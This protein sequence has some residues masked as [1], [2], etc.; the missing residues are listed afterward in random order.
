MED[1]REKVY[2]CTLAVEA[3]MICDLLARAGISARV[4][5][6]FLAGV[7]GELPLGSTIKV[8]VDPSRAVEARAVIDE[9]QREQP[10]IST[11]PVAVPARSALRS[12]LWFVAGLL[13]GA[14]A[15]YYASRSPATSQSADFNGDGIEDEIYHYEGVTLTRIDLDRD[16]DGKIDG[17]WFHDLG[18][19]PKRYEG[20]ENFDGRFEWVSELKDGQFVTTTVDW[21]G[22]GE[23]DSVMHFERGVLHHTDVYDEAGQRIVSRQH[24][25]D[26]AWN[27]HNEVDADGDG[28]FERRVEL[29]RYGEPK[30]R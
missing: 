9:W 24:F 12:S 17:R 26:G 27:D 15:L 21:N 16:S 4:D 23:R 10:P 14:G 25:V 19:V 20:D 30:Q 13:V 28:I 22:D 29:D 5:G 11:A 18:G 2:E 1:L 6:E 8:R 7:A 3:Y